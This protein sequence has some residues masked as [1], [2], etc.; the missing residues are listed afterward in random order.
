MRLHPRGSSDRSGL[1]V[2]MARIVVCVVIFE[3]KR[4]DRRHLR[5]VFSGLRPMEMPGLAWKNDDASRR[6]GFH[7]VAIE[8]LSETDVKHP[9]HHGV[10]AIF[11]MFVRHQFRAAG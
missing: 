7:L 9:R 10:D 11:W 2:L 3:A 4:T 1:R 6:I 5:D 8:G